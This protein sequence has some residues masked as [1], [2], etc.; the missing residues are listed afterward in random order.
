ME[1]IM[2]LEALAEQ[3]EKSGEYRVLKR[4][5]S[6]PSREAPAD[7][8]TTKG[9]FLDVETT[10]L[11]A[12]TDEIIEFGA[13][14]FEYNLET[15]EIYNII[16]TYSHFQDPGRR[17][18]KKIIEITGI[19]DQDV[20]G[21]VIPAH[22]LEELFSDV[23][24][25]VAHNASFDRPF[26]EKLHPLFKDKPWACSI[27]DIPWMLEGLAGRKLEYLAINFGYFFNAHR[28]VDDCLAGVTILSEALPKTGRLAMNQLLESASTP[29]FRFRAVG[30]PFDKKDLLR[31]RGYRWNSIDRVWVR[32]VHGGSEGL[33][34]DWLARNIYFKTEAVPQP[35]QIPPTLRYSARVT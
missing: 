32:D 29:I 33:E 18:P 15:G 20:Q 34:S 2:G 25:I 3:L 9:V 35:I 10:G 22:E 1:N 5:R 11:R 19:T 7:T 24:L 30:A 23:A 17:I 21:Q 28:A 27:E 31:E 4:I 13:V 14:K 16:E 8:P 6:F 12:S 26:A